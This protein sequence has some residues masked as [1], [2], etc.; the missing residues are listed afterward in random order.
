M[1]KV[2]HSNVAVKSNEPLM[3]AYQ[4]PFY[5]IM[6]SICKFNIEIVKNKWSMR[7]QR[8]GAHCASL[9]IVHKSPPSFSL[10]E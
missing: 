6:P 5:K 7:R 1:S 4:A 8:D 10:M 2:M 3:K 9:T